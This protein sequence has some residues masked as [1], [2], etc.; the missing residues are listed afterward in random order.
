MPLH[1]TP[2]SCLINRCHNTTFDFGL[3][4]MTPVWLQRRVEQPAR[5]QNW[6]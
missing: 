2:E 1:E 6:R 4:V 3:S 5:K